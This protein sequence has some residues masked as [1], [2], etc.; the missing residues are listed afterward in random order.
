MTTRTAATRRLARKYGPAW[1]ATLHHPGLTHRRIE[2]AVRKARRPWRTAAVTAYVVIL[3]A[4]FL[5]W[6]LL[7]LLP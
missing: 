2:R 6:V 3:A 1:A 7:V 5:L 4:L